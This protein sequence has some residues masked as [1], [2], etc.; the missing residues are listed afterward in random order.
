MANNFWKEKKG[1]YEIK[2]VTIKTVD[3]A[4]FDYFDK[5]IAP[6]VE[7]EKDRSKVPIIFASGERWRLIRKNNFRDENGT[8][9]LPLISIK[10]SDIDRTPGFGG[11][12]QE[13]PEIVISK[14]I[15]P[16]TPYRQNTVKTRQLNYPEPTQP[17][18]YEYLTL[19]FPDFSTIHYEI[20]IWTQYQAQMNEILEKIFYRY[21]HMDS[22]VMPVEYDG[23]LPKGNSYYFVGFRDG[24][25]TPQVNVEEFTDQERIL[26]YLYMIK[27]PVYLMLDP[28]DETLSYG[29]DKEDRGGKNVVYKQQS[30]TK[31]ELKEKFI[32]LEEFQKLFG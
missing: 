11:M 7:V 14:R 24:N 28:A 29:R 22:F 2:P 19:P 23:K 20:I 6:T 30:S 18:I 1:R 17:P 3:G 13:V 16:E 10:R 25:V 12:A 27:V 5:K 21:E 32:S 8:L 26:K 4:I 15:H 31:I 9:Q